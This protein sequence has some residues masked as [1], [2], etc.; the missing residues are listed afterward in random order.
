MPIG[1]VAYNK[2]IKRKL[3]KLKNKIFFGGTFSGNPLSTRIGCKTFEFILKNQNL[4]NTKINYLGEFIENEINQFCE[5][6]SINFKFLRY[7]S[8]LKPAFNL[9]KQTKK[10]EKNEYFTEF[11]NYLLKNKIFI[12]SNCC[13]FISYCHNKH[14]CSKLVAVIKKFLLF[15]K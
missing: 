12:S 1:I 8:I 15:N 7:E 13:F 2:I 11:R 5:K 9:K 6:K 4:I 3:E 14:D 10:F